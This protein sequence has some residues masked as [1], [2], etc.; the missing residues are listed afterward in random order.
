MAIIVDRRLNGKG[1]SQ[2][3]RRRFIERYKQK[4]K[5]QV[6]DLAKDRSL[7]G[8]LREGEVSVDGTAEPT[9]KHNYKTGTKEWVH[10]GN[11]R[12][13]K[14]DIIPKPFED[15]DGDTSS[16]SGGGEGEDSFTFVLTKE[17]FIDIYFGDLELPN[18]IKES[19][20]T[21]VDLKRKRAGYTKYGIPAR[22]NIKKTF[23]QSIA[24][25]ISTRSQIRQEIETLE[26]L[27]ILTEAEQEQ[28]EYFKKK[29]PR[30]LDDEDVRYDHYT[31][32]KIPIR[33]AVMFCIMDVSG[34]MDEMHKTLSKKFFLLLYLFLQRDYESVELVFIR[35]T[36]TA[37]E[38]GEYEFF[39]STHTGGTEVY[40]AYVLMNQI[41][42]DRYDVSRINIYVAQ[43]SDGDIFRQDLVNCA[44]YVEAHILP[45]VQYFVY[46]QVNL[47]GY[48]EYKHFNSQKDLFDL[49]LPLSYTHKNLKLKLLSKESDIYTIFRELFQKE[50]K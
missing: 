47:R 32:I 40:S 4:I 29:K 46:I 45:K 17:E 35:H 34:S 43:A 3:N 28:L 18:F 38:V 23:E 49:L 2:P 20:C 31:Q 14:G 42:E 48:H 5:Q 24:R 9:F 37:E 50:G 6:H 25:K 19:L 10:P 41:I 12:Y 16:G 15:E 11:D 8:V 36:D 26:A 13:G 21:S 30:Y 44:P 39:H 27:P 22:L 7:K 33:H 1:K